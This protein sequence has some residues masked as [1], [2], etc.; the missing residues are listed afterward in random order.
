MYIYKSTCT[1]V[2]TSWYTMGN[3]DSQINY[4]YNVHEYMYMYIN[5]TMYTVHCTSTVLH[6][7]NCTCTST[8]PCTSTVLH[9]HVLQQHHVN[10]HQQCMYIN[11]TMYMYMYINST[12]CTCSST[13]PCKYTS[14]MRVHVHQ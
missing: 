6:V 10:I 8:V 1:V 2:S 5:I 12:M 14:T 9:V 13:A 7:Y 11:S 4:M 3:I